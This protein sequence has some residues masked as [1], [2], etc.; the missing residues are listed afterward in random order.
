MKGPC[1]ALGDPLAAPPPRASNAPSP[2]RAALEARPGGPPT[3]H[4]VPSLAPAVRS[5][6]SYQL[7]GQ[8]PGV[9]QQGARQQDGAV[10][11]RP[12]VRGG[13]RGAGGRPWRG[14]SV[15][16]QAQRGQDQVANTCGREGAGGGSGPR[17]GRTE[18]DWSGGGKG[19][20]PAPRGGGRGAGLRLARASRSLSGSGCPARRSR[21]GPGRGDGPGVSRPP[22]DAGIW[23]PGRGV[24]GRHRP[25][26]APS[27]GPGTGRTERRGGSEGRRRGGPPGEAPLGGRGGPARCGMP[28]TP[29]RESGTP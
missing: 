14:G 25:G 16:P 7:R 13:P 2:V 12:G 19:R 11:L 26:P 24:R 28:R 10:Q 9:G 1:P 3:A 20:G 6:V 29:G 21:R 17:G 22:P 15:R 18:E 5:L 8:L 4:P 23:A 27:P